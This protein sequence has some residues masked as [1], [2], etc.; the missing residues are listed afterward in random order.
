MLFVLLTQVGP[1]LFSREE[2]QALSL[3]TESGLREALKEYNLYLVVNEYQTSYQRTQAKLNKGDEF[4]R[5][6]FVAGDKVEDI[7]AFMEKFDLDG[8]VMEV[9]NV[10]ELSAAPAA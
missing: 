6:M 8:T 9:T 4:H 7:Q 3:N 2:V 10:Y 5:T 1:D